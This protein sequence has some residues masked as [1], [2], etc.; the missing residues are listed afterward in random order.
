[1]AEPEAERGAADGTPAAA[2][3]PAAPPQTT[4]RATLL[5]AALGMTLPFGAPRVGDEWGEP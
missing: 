1:M 3:Q 4:W 2:R 5:E